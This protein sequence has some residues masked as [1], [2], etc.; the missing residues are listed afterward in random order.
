MSGASPRYGSSVRFHAP[1]PPPTLM[2]IT[3]ADLQTMEAPPQPRALRLLQRTS[4]RS[5]RRATTG[6]NAPHP[7]PRAPVGALGK[8]GAKPARLRMSLASTADTV[9]PGHFGQ[10]N[11]ESD[12]EPGTAPTN[13]PAPV[14][15]PLRGRRNAQ[16]PSRN[17]QDLIPLGHNSTRRQAAR[18]GG[19]VTRRQRRRRRPAPPLQRTSLSVRGLTLKT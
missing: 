11:H 19:G 6:S 14:S 12:P 7:V 9:T 18:S 15:S 8:H 1:Q 10:R 13:P 17:T 16:S 5:A 2:Q 3:S 4:V